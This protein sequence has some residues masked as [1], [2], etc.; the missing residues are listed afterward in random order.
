MTEKVSFIGVFSSIFEPLCK[1]D[2][3]I[4]RNGVEQLFSNQKCLENLS[5]ERVILFEKNR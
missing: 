5:K 2:L 1:H 4:L 3:E